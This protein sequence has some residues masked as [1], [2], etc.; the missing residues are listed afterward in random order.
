[1]LTVLTTRIIENELV[2]ERVG[3]QIQSAVDLSVSAAPELEELDSVALYELA[4]EQGREIS[5]RVLFL[6]RAGVVQTDSFSVLNGRR[7][8][9]K[10]ILEVLSGNKDTSYGF[11]RIE[12]S[13]GTVFWSVYYTSAII[14]NSETIGAV[15][16]SQSIQDVVDNANRIRSQFLYV[17]VIALVLILIVVYFST[18]HVSKPIEQLKEGATNVAGGNFKTRVNIKGD[19]ELSDLGNAF[20]RMTMQLETVDKQ[21]SEFV[22]NASHELRTPLTSMKILAESLL[23]QE[24]VEEA[25]YQD[26]LGDIDR[27]VDRLNHLINDLLLLT[28]IEDVTEVPNATETN[29]CELVEQVVKMLR[30]IADQKFIEIRTDFNGT[31]YTECASGMMR[32]AVNNLV[33]N[34]IKYSPEGGSVDVRLYATPKNIFIEVEDCGEGIAQE[35]INH[36][37]E[38]FYRVDKARS[39]ETGG[40]GLGLH[41]VMKVVNLHGGR[42]EIKSSEGQGSVFTIVLPI[43]KK[44]T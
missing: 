2:E 37:F 35:H 20:N 8:E 25:V 3:E 24:G 5:G 43:T 18:I 6:N 16:L 29:L 21:R 19:N 12:N 39:R 15:V 42:V 34:A 36:L 27:E 7:L 32:Q 1:V 17:F 22:S 33:D 28:K 31:V 26:F 4:L 41:I 10:E 11:H 23:Y 30:P 14:H 13:N 44:H 40:N 38:R 9:S